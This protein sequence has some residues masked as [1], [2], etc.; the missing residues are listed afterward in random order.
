MSKTED[1]KK[2]RHI[3]PSDLHGL[4]KLGTQAVKGVTRI[5]E[6][7]HQSVWRS[8]GAPSGDEPDKTRGF[9]GLVYK[10]IYK[11]THW[12]ESGV[13]KH[14]AMLDLLEQTQPDSSQRMA[15][16]S[17]MNGVMG[18]SLLHHRNP[19]SIDMSMRY[20]GEALDWQAMPVMPEVTGKILVLIHGLCMNDLQWS[21]NSAQSH[22]SMLAQELG[23]TP[24]YLRYNS[25]LHSSIN[26]RELSGQL[27]EMLE[28]WPVEVE[29]ITILAHSMG[30]LLTRG[31]FHYAQ[32][33]GL[34]WP[35][36]LKNIIFLG[37]PHHGAPLE[38]MGNLLDVVLDLTS[39]T[40]PFSRIG[41]LRS[42][43]ITDL[44]HGHVLD[45]DWHGLDR[46][47]RKPDARKGMDLPEGVACYAVAATLSAPDGALKHSAIGDGL[48]PVSSALGEHE[49]GHYELVFA[50]ESQ[51]TVYR[52]G[53]L[54]LLSSPEVAQQLLKW[55]S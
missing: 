12:L 28:H 53:H 24:L 51:L 48:V 23:Y 21:M 54:E 50:P 40:A 30:G 4:A 5:V 55:L 18:D 49:D 43:G 25:G 3:K 42:A 17:V 16:I 20:Q 14:Q 13:D 32:E 45:E 26:G 29:E 9:T 44:R 7:V 27:E 46:F 1:S 15:L 36:Y 11:A 22:G 39:Y 19:F 37:T 33:D 6:G 35:G 52:T 31:A 10:S 8:L 38:R 34:N 41:K 47:H 2:T